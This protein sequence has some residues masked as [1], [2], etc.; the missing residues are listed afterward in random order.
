MIMGSGIEQQHVRTVGQC[1]YGLLHERAEP[2]GQQPGQVGSPRSAADHL[3]FE[4][5]AT[6][7]DHCR[8]PRWIMITAGTDE[9]TRKAHPAAADDRGGG[10]EGLRLR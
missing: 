4:H 5:P 8:R 1:T 6:T 3:P 9:P 10:I 2:Q 7:H